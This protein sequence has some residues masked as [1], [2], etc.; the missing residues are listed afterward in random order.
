MIDRGSRGWSEGIK[1]CFCVRGQQVSERLRGEAMQDFEK[2][3]RERGRDVEEGGGGI[4]QGGCESKQRVFDGRPP[5]HTMSTGYS[6][7]TRGA[8]I[9]FPGGGERDRLSVGR[10]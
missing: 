7:Q 5:I 8:G 6:R 1:N 9:Y 2:K 10:G 4:L 3:E